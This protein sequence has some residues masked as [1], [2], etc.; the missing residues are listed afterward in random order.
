MLTTGPDSKSAY[1][2]EAADPVEDDSLAFNVNGFRMTDFIYPSYFEIFR[3]P[4]STKFDYR[5]KWTDRPFHRILA[6]GYQIMFSDGKRTQISRHR[7]AK[8][9][10]AESIEDRLQHRSQVRKVRPD[11]RER[12]KADPK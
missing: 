12:S 8:A 1:A 7:L 6:G 4:N 11:R 2:Y 10:R 3:K 9:T 5:G